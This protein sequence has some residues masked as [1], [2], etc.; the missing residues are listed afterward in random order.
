MIEPN[1]PHDEHGRPLIN[2][3]YETILCNFTYNQRDIISEAVRSFTSPNNPVYDVE[4][5]RKIMKELWKDKRN[6]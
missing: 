5:I 3:P 6:V 2:D 1:E 4:E